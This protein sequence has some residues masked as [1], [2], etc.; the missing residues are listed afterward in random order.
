MEDHIFYKNLI[1]L[2]NI[3]DFSNLYFNK[4]ELYSKDNYKLNTCTDDDIN[5][6]IYYYHLY[7]TIKNLLHL[8]QPARCFV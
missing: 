2:E 1:I 8:L 4:F 3:N 5:K 6:I 7:H